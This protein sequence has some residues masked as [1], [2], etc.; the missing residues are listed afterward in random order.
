MNPEHQRVTIIGAGP[1]G[2]MAAEVLS[3]SGIDIDVYDAMPSAGR[4]F[5]MAGKG[6]M[7]ITHA[8]PFDGFIQR[9]AGPCKQLE[10]ILRAFPPEALRKWVQGLGVATFV[11]SSG[12]VFP[13]DMKAAPLLRSWLHRLRSNGVRFHMRH[14][15]NG[16]TPQGGLV[17]T[18]PDG[19]ICV[20]AE[21]LVLALGGGS[22]PQLGSNGAWV[23]WMR[24]RGLEVRPLQPANC[25][26]E[27]NW[28]DCLRR[29]FAGQPI[30]PVRLHFADSQ[31][32]NFNQQGEMILTDYGLEGGLIYALSATLREQIAAAGSATITLDL[33]PNQNFETVAARLNLKRAKDSV[34]NVL[35]KQLHLQG[36]KVALLREIVSAETLKNPTQLALAIK[37]LP[38]KLVATRPLTEAIS[39]AGGVSFAELNS[40]LMLHQCPG[41]FC[42]GEMLD[43]EAPT[44]GYLLTGC[45]ASG[46][47]AG[48]GVLDWLSHTSG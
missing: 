12:R 39:S 5:L 7:N 36:S 31:G 34:S 28:S 25:G 8:E 47:A 3:Q 4:K 35:R 27:V 14:R 24:A 22:W 11:G 37:A 44:G 15:W 30:K 41:V 32:C 9:Y 1:S 17:F 29:H 48:Y 23:P 40:G 46:R 43:W 33:L 21:T 38:I 6:G 26:F 45:L 20:S 42:C 18:T 16:W 2:L 13:A 10:A 19:E